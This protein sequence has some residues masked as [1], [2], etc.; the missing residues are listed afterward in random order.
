MCS[1]TA[2]IHL[3]HVVVYHMSVT[4][5]QIVCTHVTFKYCILYR[6]SWCQKR[7]Y[8][9]DRSHD[10]HTLAHTTCYH[11]PS[12]VI[13]HVNVLLQGRCDTC[14]SHRNPYDIC[15]STCAPI[16]VHCIRHVII[17]IWP[18]ILLGCLIQ[19]LTCLMQTDADGC[20]KLQDA[21][22]SLKRKAINDLAT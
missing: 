16:F 12:F 6:F 9:R 17:C 18:C 5:A 22:T 2:A 10:D 13:A 14:L 21:K 1:I 11:I 20:P 15:Q 7:Q 4:V 3:I 8:V 19:I